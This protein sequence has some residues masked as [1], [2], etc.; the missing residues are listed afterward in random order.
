[1]DRRETDKDYVKE[2]IESQADFI[3]L[4]GKIDSGIMEH[5]KIL[6]ENGIYVNYY[7]TDSPDEIRRLFEYGVDFPLVNDIVKSI[8]VAAEFNIK[9]VQP[10]FVVKN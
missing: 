2:T 9:P 10:L 8:G 3:Q 5:A 7:G 4:R 6:K 1:M